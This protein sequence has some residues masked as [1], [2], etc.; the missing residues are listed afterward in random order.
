M[1]SSECPPRLGPL[2]GG[3]II[4]AAGAADGWRWVFLV[5]LF[6][7]AVAIPMAAWRLPR[8]EMRTRR[9]FDPIGLGLLTGGLLLL[10]VPLVEGQQD[11]WP[12]WTWIC[13]GCCAVVL[14]L[15]T[16]L[17]A[18]ADRAAAIRC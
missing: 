16:A 2:L 6:I 13:F 11:G 5:N 9:G 7:G 3:I 14:A 12:A 1:P 15:L 18:A 17:G 8:G 10:L 4:A